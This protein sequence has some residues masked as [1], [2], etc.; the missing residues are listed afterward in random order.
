MLKKNRVVYSNIKEWSPYAF[1]DGRLFIGQNPAASE[2][3][4]E[5]LLKTYLN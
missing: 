3:V 4:A 5:E 1:V 2:K